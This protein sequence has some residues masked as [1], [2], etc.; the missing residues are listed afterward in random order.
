MMGPLKAPGP[1]GL[2]A[3]FYQKAWGVVG[4]DVTSTVLWI[5]QGERI[6]SSMAEALLVLIPEKE[7]PESI[8]HFRPITCVM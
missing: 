7:T 8:K 6:D 4:D 5:L 2:H 3:I 1:D